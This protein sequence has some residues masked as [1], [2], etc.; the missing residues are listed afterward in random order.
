MPYKDKKELYA[1]QKRYRQRVKT[2][3]QENDARL[4]EF[5][6]RERQQANEI[7]D[8]FK[9]RS[10]PPDLEKLQFQ[11]ENRMQKSQIQELKDRCTFLGL[12]L[13]NYERRTEV[14]ELLV[15]SS[16]QA[17]KR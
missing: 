16:S 5:E 8:K 4:K 1:A 6:E 7:S 3:K 13:A 2:K 9:Q 10:G 14:L 12:L 15:A 11:E 17:R